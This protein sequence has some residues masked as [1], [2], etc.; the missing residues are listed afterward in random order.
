MLIQICPFQPRRS[1]TPVPESSEHTP[2]ATGS[3]H[4]E[5]EV[6]PTPPIPVSTCLEPTNHIGYHITSSNQ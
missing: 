5:E 4:V 6:A 1:P 2:S 3:H